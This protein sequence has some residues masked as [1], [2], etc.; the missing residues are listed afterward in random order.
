MFVNAAGVT[1]AL[2]VALSVFTPPTPFNW[3]W[4]FNVMLVPTNGAL[5][6]LFADVPVK[7]STP[8]VSVRLFGHAQAVEIEQVSQFFMHPFSA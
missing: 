1:D 3:S 5:N 8:V 4:V 7:L 2:S 6:V